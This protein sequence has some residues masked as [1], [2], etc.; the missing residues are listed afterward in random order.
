MILLAQRLAIETSKDYRALRTWYSVDW[1]GPSVLPQ[2]RQQQ[3]PKATTT[4]HSLTHS[5]SHSLTHSRTYFTYLLTYFL[6]YLLT[7]FTYLLTYLVSGC[8]FLE[9]AD[10]MLS[11]RDSEPRPGMQA[12]CLRAGNPWTIRSTSIMLRASACP[13]STRTSR[14]AA[15]HQRGPCSPGSWW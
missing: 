10:G 8:T 3:L 6:T 15:G 1:A 14:R 11:H 5:L 4:T 13:A 12:H 7:Y 2:K 9:T